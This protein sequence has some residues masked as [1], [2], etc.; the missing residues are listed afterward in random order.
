MG[1]T[2]V[3]SVTSGSNSK[4]RSD[5]EPEKIYI[6]LQSL[7]RSNALNRPEFDFGFIFK[8]PQPSILS[9][10]TLPSPL[11]DGSLFLEHQHK[12]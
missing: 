1:E 8:E 11:P 9:L 10:I 4:T 5:N 2:S 7:A 6:L 3:S 12:G